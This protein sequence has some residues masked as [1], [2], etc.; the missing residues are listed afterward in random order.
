MYY[1]TF[2]QFFSDENTENSSS[3]KM[4]VFFF[5]KNGE[6]EGKTGLL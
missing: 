1:R 4:P 6:Q 5:S 2:L 3:I